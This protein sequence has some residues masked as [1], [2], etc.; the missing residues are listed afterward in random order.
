M[1]ANKIDLNLCT[2]YIFSFLLLKENG[3]DFINQDL[4]IYYINQLKSRS[5][6]LKILVA[7]GGYGGGQKEAFDI[8]A[9]NW[10]ARTIFINKIYNFLVSN[11][12]SGVDIDW[13]YPEGAGKQNLVTLLQELKQKLGWQYSVSCAIGAG[14]YR[15]GL[16]YDIPGIF[17]NSDFVNVMTYDMHGPP[18]LYVGLHA[19][20]YK[21]AADPESTANAH[22]SIQLIVNLGGSLSKIIFGIPIYAKVRQ[23]S[24][25]NNNVF[26]PATIADIT[27]IPYRDVCQRVRNGQYSERYSNEQQSAYAFSGS[28]WLSYDNIASVDLKAKYINVNNMGGAMFW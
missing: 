28:T 9:G 7:V 14:P 13:E 18:Q 1:S 25:S 17:S 21:G 10:Y 22:E 16:S 11:G 26:A 12:L 24:T 27:E 20:L 2:H 19:A 3:Y 6:S 15:T 23:L 5:S 4:A 8:M